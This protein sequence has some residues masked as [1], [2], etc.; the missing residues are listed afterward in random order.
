MGA[1]VRTIYHLLCILPLVLGVSLICLGAIISVNSDG[2]CKD[3]LPLS[4][5]VL[6]IIIGSLATV[7][8]I[9]CC[10][11]SYNNS[12]KT[13][14]A[15]SLLCFLCSISFLASVI[16]VWKYHDNLHE[17]L[18]VC[19]KE[20]LQAY[21]NK[22]TVKNL[23]DFVQRQYQCCGVTSKN[24]YEKLKITIPTACCVVDNGCQEI[25]EVGCLET[26]EKQMRNHTPGIIIICCFCLLIMVLITYLS[27]SIANQINRDQYL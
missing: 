4:L 12:S 10:C 2:L 22:S 6:A 5:P 19:L 1:V 13:L 17:K 11:G 18:S 9:L 7:T 14:V 3:H 26:M 20:S 24:D 21:E 16:L 23:L 25:Y 15:G 8:S 27:C